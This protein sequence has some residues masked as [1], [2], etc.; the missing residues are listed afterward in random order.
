ME[1]IAVKHRLALR[2]ID[3]LSC[4][5]DGLA[6]TFEWELRL[7]K[8]SQ[9]RFPQPIARLVGNNCNGCHLTLSAV[10]IDRIHALPPDA[11]ATCEECGRILVHD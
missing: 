11:I 4:S 10:A 8:R 5:W 7:S 9:H 6:P 3:A 1:E 2:C